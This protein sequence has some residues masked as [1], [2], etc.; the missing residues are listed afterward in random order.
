MDKHLIEFKKKL[1]ELKTYRGRHTELVTVMVPAGFDINKVTNQVSQEKGT[2]TNIK[3]R[4]TKQ[5]VMTALEKILQRLILFKKTPENGVAIFC[6]NIGNERDEWIMESLIPP[7]PLTTRAYR[8]DQTFFLDP[9]KDM[10]QP[11]EVF[12]LL[13]LDRGGAT[14]GFLK[15]KRIETVHTVKS[16]IFGKFRAGG[17]SAARI[18]RAREGMAKA[19]YNKVA[20][21]VKKY[22]SEGKGFL[23][24]GPGPNKDEFIKILNKNL[25]SKVIAVKDTG[26]SDEY[27]LRELVEKS[28]DVLSKTELMHEKIIL[29]EFFKRIAKGEPVEYGKANI[30][31]VLKIGSAE[32]I[33]LSENLPQ[34]VIEEISDLADETNIEVEFV[35]IETEE[36]QEF[37]AIGG[38]GALLRY[39]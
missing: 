10:L 29:K 36:G 22:F 5:N 20:D 33:I 28:A 12:G 30:K 34:E 3:S 19:F 31:N 15:G 32:K 7:E 6:G 9:F 4:K 17:Q 18:E 27:G 16:F 24:G 25:A 11:K 1:K 8:C 38:I 2:A 37:R 26:Y 13:V 21:S 39:A 35:S 23:V 14:L